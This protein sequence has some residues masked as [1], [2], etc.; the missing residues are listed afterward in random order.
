ML[1]PHGNVVQGRMHGV[2]L[3][4]VRHAWDTNIYS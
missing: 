2:D 1:N 4:T 3:C